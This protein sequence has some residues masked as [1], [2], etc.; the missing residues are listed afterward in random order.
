MHSMTDG[1]YGPTRKTDNGMHTATAGE[2]L[3][4]GDVVM[5]DYTNDSGLVS[6]TASPGAYNHPESVWIKAAAVAEAEIE[7]G[8]NIFGVVTEA[9]ATAGKPFR[10]CLQGYCDLLLTAAVTAA[11]TEVGIVGSTGK[12]GPVAAGAGS[13]ILGQSQATA[14]NGDLCPVYWDGCNPRFR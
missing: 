7:R 12:V 10:M 2:A 4:V 6:L 11:F 9:Q 13:P 5:P 1:P 14:S 3:V 8:S